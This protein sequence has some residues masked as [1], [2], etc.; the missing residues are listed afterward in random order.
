MSKVI[1]KKGLRVDGNMKVLLSVVSVLLIIGTAFIAGI[2]AV[3]VNAAKTTVFK[4]GVSSTSHTAYTYPTNTMQEPGYTNGTYAMAATSSVEH[5]NVY[6]ATDQYSFMLL[7]EV[8]DSLTVLSPNATPTVMPWLAA[9]WSVSPASAS[10]TT[11]DPVTGQRMPVAYIWTVNLGPGVQW[12]DWTPANAASTYTFSNTTTFNAFNATTG[13]VQTYTHQY[14]WPSVTMRTEYVQSADVILSWKILQSS[15]NFLDVYNNVVNVVPTSNLTV[16]FYLSAQSASF[17]FYTLETM[18]LPYHIWVHHDFA[19]SIT[20]AWNYTGAANGYDTWNMDYNPSTGTASGLVGSGPFMISNSYGIPQGSWLSGQYFKLFVNPHYFVQYVPYLQQYTPKFWELYVPQYSSVSAAAT[21]ELLGQVDTIELGLPLTFLPRIAIMPHTYI[22]NKP[23]T[24]YNYIQLNSYASNAPFNLTSVRQ[25]LNY[26]TNKAYLASVIYQGYNALG[27]PIVPVSDVVWHNNNTPQYTYN[28]AKAMA[29][30]NA[31]SG[32]NYD[33]TTH[34]YNYKGKTVTADMQITVAGE[35]PLGVEGALVIAK[36]WDSIGIPTTVSQVAFTTLVSNLITYSYNAINLG[37]SGIS[38]DPTSDFFYFYNTSVGLGSGFYLGPFSNITFSNGT[39]M[40][41]TQV[42][43][44]MNSLTNELNTITNFTMR[45]SI[46]YEIQSIAAQESTI[47]NLGYPVDI[48]PF[49]NTT[50]TGITKDALPYS[51]F[52]YWNFLS[53][54]ERTASNITKPPSFVPVKLGVGVVTPKTIY[55]NGQTGNATIQVRNQYGQPVPGIAVLVGYSPQG[56]LINTT[57]DKGVT[58]SLGQYTWEFHVLSTQ[59]LT[60][61]A[62]YLSQLNISAAAYSPTNSTVQPGLGSTFI[63]VAPQPVAYATSTMPVLV[64][65]QPMK[66][67]NITVTDATTGSPIGG[68]A[69]TVQALSGA[70][71]MENTTSSQSVAQTTSYNPNFI[72]GFQNVTDGNVAD[73]NLTSIS[74]VTNS[75]GVISVLLG[76]NSSINF[77]AMG[78]PFESYVFLGNYSAGGPVVGVGPYVSIGEL[79]SASNPN[80]FGVQQPVELPIEVAQT[81]PSVS[82]SLSASSSTTASNGSV[83]VT[84]KVTNA[85]TGSPIAGYSLT[86][87]SQNALGANRGYFTSASGTQ[88][89]AYNPNSFFGSSFLPGIS[90]VTNS[91]GIAVANF[92]AGLYESV[93]NSTG[94]FTNFKAQKFTDN[95]LIPFDEFQLSALGSG[96]EVATTTVTSAQFYNSVAPFPVAYAYFQDSVI[97]NGLTSLKGNATYNVFVNTTLNTPNGPSTSGIPVRIAVSV[98]SVNSTNGTTAANGSVVFTY[99]APN[100]SV[101]TPVLVTVKA[102]GVNPSTTTET[103]YLLPIYPITFTETGL[104]SGA[105]WYVNLTNGQTFSSTT[106]TIT[107]NEPN[108]NYSYTIATM[109]R[110]YS[111]SPSSG[112]FAVNGTALSE[113]IK[114]VLITY[115]IRFNETGLPPGTE[116]FVNL[117]GGHSASSTSSTITFAAPNGTYSYSIATVNKSWSSN[118]GSVTVNGASVSQSAAFTEVTYTVALTETGLPTGTSWTIILNEVTKTSTGSIMMFNEPNGTYAYNVSTPISGGTGIRYVTAGSGSVT[119]NGN[120]PSVSVPYN[121]QYYLAMSS[122]PSAGG[123]ALPLSGWYNASSTVTISATASSGYAFISWTGTGTGGYTG[124]S[125]SHTITI[126]APITET[127]N[128]SKLYAVTFT[129]SRLP[130]GT[131]WFVNLSDGQ[132]FSSTTSV[133]IFN[134]TN[135]IYDYNIA[136]TNKS[137]FSIGGS[138]TIND[139]STSQSFTFT[140]VTYTVTFTESGL[141]SGTNW[142]VTLAGLTKYSTSTTITFNEPN[143][144]YTYTVSNTSYYYTSSHSGI[145]TV[146]GAAQS[147][148]IAYQHYSYITGTVTPSNAVITIN[149]NPVTVTSGNF[150]VTV[151]AGTYALAASLSGYTTYYSNFTLSA[152]QTHTLTITL[153]I[154]SSCHCGMFTSVSSSSKQ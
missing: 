154:R 55:T 50:F 26:A 131:E 24:S 152:G 46:A 74:G 151:T 76:V 53:L 93:Y 51:S 45:L 77:T 87:M 103:I 75:S 10:M 71:I 115:T 40:S 114:F 49:T 65:G 38:G 96:G 102:G 142:S 33:S 63:D 12:T 58:N 153:H 124:T 130:P 97:Y 85:T 54:H 133:L 147:E 145:I 34:Q 31:T 113:S 21:A 28:P 4:N 140:E 141:S 15:L 70:V 134:E 88:V 146:N 60:Y 72:F 48:L 16:Q 121:T 32:M 35:D 1:Y 29:L 117:S 6:L 47:I 7:D 95:Y 94:V 79:T 69:Y 18:I 2:F 61:T 99:A 23:S 136:T 110:E 27:Q 101:I 123:T 19:S 13:A 5:L 73:Y 92:S 122:S 112:T 17:L 100:V 83:T 82:I 68:Y 139:A 106:N 137:W 118:G 108:G 125:A 43:N 149:G 39:F 11:F 42:T 104:Q 14:K 90:L 22:Y 59:P 127:A 37:L 105:T 109:N 52:M 41:G 86:L 80:G 57:S 56:A 128:F 84:A 25:A 111:K 148:N 126:S 36:E 81:A 119:V 66:Q 107:L 89:Q 62:D 91:S 20:T 30:L 3:P 64:A 44:L 98:G 120:S 135:G 8:Y 67:F 132:S 144:T 129:E 116:W 138:F 9:S 78:S 143:G 150:N